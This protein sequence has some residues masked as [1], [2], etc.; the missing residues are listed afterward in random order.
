MKSNFIPYVIFILLEVNVKRSFLT[1]NW[2][3]INFSLL[4]S[5]SI[6]VKFIN[7]LIKLAVYEFEST[8]IKCLKINRNQNWFK[9]DITI[10]HQLSSLYPQQINIWYFLCLFCYTK[11]LVRIWVEKVE[12]R[13]WT[14]SWKLTSGK[15]RGGILRW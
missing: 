2:N 12:T 11:T 5:I 6:Y 1:I 3:F 14:R 8:C 15:P 9:V 13:V 7:K 10:S 4:E